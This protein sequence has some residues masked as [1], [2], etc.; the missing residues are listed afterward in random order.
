MQKKGVV[1]PLIRRD[2]KRCPGMRGLTFYSDLQLF[3]AL[4]Y[5]FPGVA[6]EELRT[7]ERA[8]L[9]GMPVEGRANKEENTNGR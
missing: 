5:L 2:G 1:V 8:L 9:G 7:I 6:D 3:R 4:L